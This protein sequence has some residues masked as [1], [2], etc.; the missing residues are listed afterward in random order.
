MSK[1]KANEL[2]PELQASIQTHLDKLEI[3]K[4]ELRMKCSR[5]YRDSGIEF[6]AIKQKVGHGNWLLAAR[7][8]G[9]TPRTAQLCIFIAKANPSEEILDSHPTY[10]T[11]LRFIRKGKQQEYTDRLET[12]IEALKHKPNDSAIICGDS[13][14]WLRARPA[15]SVSFFITDPPYGIGKKYDDWQ[16]ADNPKDHFTFI[17]P[18][19]DEMVRCLAPGGILVMWQDY[20]Y[21][22]YFHD[23][24]P[25][26]QIDCAPIVYRGA[27]V[28]NPLIRYQKPPGAILF[29][30]PIWIP[31]V[32]GKHDAQE[33]YSFHPCAKNI[34]EVEQ[35]VK[36]Y[37]TKGSLVV[38]PFGG[39]GTTPSV[40]KK[41][42]R[43]YIAIERNPEYVKLIQS[44]LVEE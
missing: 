44:R 10:D 15:G 43:K 6:I 28:W 16:E 19:W 36:S 21:I 11:I 9:I 38:D 41:L 8:L 13:M 3:L 18:F 12:R 17:K 39:T 37:T 35:V 24:F 22:K 33:Y 32:E 30:S 4:P 40:C 27:K 14:E 2:T 29:T 25:G 5:A 26:C 7:S 1:T 34:R 31:P 23:W 42:G 20:R